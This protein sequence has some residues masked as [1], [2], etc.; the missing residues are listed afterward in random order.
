MDVRAAAPPHVVLIG[1]STLDN[2]VWVEQAAEAVPPTLQRLLEKH[3][4]GATVTNLAADGFTS[5]DVLRGAPA[6][7]SY[8][9]REQAGDP[10]PTS[11]P[12]EIFH[13]LAEL[14]AMASKPTP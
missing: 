6:A 7:I 4:P 9:A 8:R 1:D 12:M 14:K 13:P 11:S 10:L 2:V 5:T 3:S